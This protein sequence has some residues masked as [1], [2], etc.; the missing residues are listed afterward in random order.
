VSFAVAAGEV[1]G[2]AGVE[3]N[4]QRE[5]V[6]VLSGLERPERG[7]VEGMQAVAVVHE[8]RHKEGLV[9][10]A[11][12]LDNLLLGELAEYTR[13]GILD[14]A[15]MRAEAASRAD[16]FDV[17]PRDL[18]QDVRA[19]SGGNQQKIVVARAL[20]SG[21]PVVV[22]AHPT[23]GVD[24]GAASAIHAKIRNAARRGAAV[25]LVSADLS[26]L[27]ATATRILVMSRGA[28]VA[29][30]PPSATDAEIGACMVGAMRPSRP[31]LLN[32]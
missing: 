23:R 24:V 13:F 15:A 20:A 14:G 7:H 10:D 26:E 27:R 28:I 5:L 16:E 29:E 19:L 4:G 6:R 11:S 2:I 21:P 1:V 12:V 18:E 31:A 3:G 32:S 8:D 25:L 30:L 9:L 17:M 22:M